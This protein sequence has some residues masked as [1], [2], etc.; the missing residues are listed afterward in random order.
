MAANV[1]IT[2]VEGALEMGSRIAENAG[3]NA[4]RAQLQSYGFYVGATMGLEPTGDPI[5]AVPASL[6]G[7]PS[8]SLPVSQIGGCRLCQ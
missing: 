7:V 8:L 3:A 6:L 5:F 4:V 1:L 2:L